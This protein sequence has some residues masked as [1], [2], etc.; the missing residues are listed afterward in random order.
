MSARCQPQCAQSIRAR[1]PPTWIRRWLPDPFAGVQAWLPAGPTSGGSSAYQ[2]YQADPFAAPL[3][4]RP[5]EASMS[6]PGPH[7]VSVTD[8]ATV[9]GWT[10]GA[11]AS[12]HR[13]RP[14]CLRPGRP[15]ADRGCQLVSS[16]A[17]TG[18]DRRSKSGP[19]TIRQDNVM[20][21]C[22]DER[23]GRRAGS[24]SVPAAGTRPR[25]P[26]SSGSR[27]SPRDWSGSHP[28]PRI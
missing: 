17:G 24:C 16:W 6:L 22:R 8:G 1:R 26:T 10:S 27:E 4:G 18:T 28:K 14:R 5:D 11:L 9:A 21:S 13:A 7:H 15:R 2:C 25:R 3:R 23:T 20:G 12:P 19:H